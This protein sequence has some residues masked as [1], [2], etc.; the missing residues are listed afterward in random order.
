MQSSKTF[1]ERQFEHQN[2]FEKEHQYFFH[3]YKRLSLDIERGDGCYLIA[4]DGKRYLDLFGG[5]AV[6]ALGY[7]HPRVK[8]AIHDQLEKYTHLSNY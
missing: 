6:N 1:E 2:M 7:N 8:K 5:L 4:R 3:T